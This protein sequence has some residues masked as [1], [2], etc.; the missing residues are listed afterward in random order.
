MKRTILALGLSAALCV[1]AMAQNLFK[2]VAQVNDSV[3]TEFEVGQRVRLLQV[4]NAPGATR[5]AALNALI[6]D[7]LRILATQAAGLELGA[8]GLNAALEEFA[9]RAN[10]STQEFVGL[11]GQAGVS[12]ETFRDFVAVNVAWRDLI[13]ARYSNRVQISEDEIDRA[14]SA[15][16]E[17]GSIRVLLSEIIMPAPPPRLAEVQARAERIAQS[18]SIAEF[19]GFARQYSATATRGP[20]WPVGLGCPEHP[21]PRLCA[22]LFWALA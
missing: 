9:G 20:R 4:L 2:P 14:L 12:Q 13:R 10:L 8:E 6:E 22:L 18:T 21:A 7:R 15:S 3:I 1:P 11:L 16:G 19:S 5:D 17:S